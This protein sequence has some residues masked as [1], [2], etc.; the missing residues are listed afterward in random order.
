MILILVEKCIFLYL[1]VSIVKV[2]AQYDRGC[3]LKGLKRHFSFLL[4]FKHR[5]LPSLPICPPRLPP[6][7][8][9]AEVSQRQRSF[10]Q[11]KCVVSG[12]NEIDFNQRAYNYIAAV[13]VT[14]ADNIQPSY[15]PV[16]QYDYI[17]LSLC[18]K[19]VSL[20]VCL[21]LT[22]PLCVPLPATCLPGCTSDSVSCLKACSFVC[23]SFN[24]HVISS[25]ITCSFACSSDA[26]M[27]EH[28]LPEGTKSMADLEWQLQ[29]NNKYMTLIHNLLLKS[30]ASC[31]TRLCVRCRMFVSLSCLV[32]MNVL[33]LL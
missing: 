28:F 22:L 20:S 4:D 33:Y 32:Y 7:S 26:H 23:V 15:L 14:D 11:A 1:L 31:L 16:L 2:G 29:K 10:Q 25:V 5:W 13:V 12:R 19:P 6:F 18:P 27:Q 30:V 21:C 3:D 24:R 8:P 9:P 17:S